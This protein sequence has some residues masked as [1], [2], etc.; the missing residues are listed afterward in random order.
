MQVDRTLV[1][2]GTPAEVLTPATL[3]A[4]YGAPLEVLTHAGLRVVVEPALHPTAGHAA[5][6]HPTGAPG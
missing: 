5:P 1:H 3:E 6:D 2:V 4:T